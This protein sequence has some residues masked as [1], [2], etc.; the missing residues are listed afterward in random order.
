MTTEDVEHIF[1]VARAS[2]ARARVRESA[3]STQSTHWHRESYAR[4]RVRESAKTRVLIVSTDASYARAR[5]REF[6]S[7]GRNRVF[8]SIHVFEEIGSFIIIH[9]LPERVA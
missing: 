8:L 7:L 6:Q 9:A 4:A 1:G 3:S 2:Y 5:V